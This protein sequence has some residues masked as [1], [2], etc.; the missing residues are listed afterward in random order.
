MVLY[1]FPIWMHCT[2]QP[3]AA[4]QRC[5]FLLQFMRCCSHFAA[6]PTHINLQPMHSW[7][8]MDT[9]IV[10]IALDWNNIESNVLHRSFVG[11]PI[12]F[13]TSVVDLSWP[14]HYPFRLSLS[15]TT[16]FSPMFH[17]LSPHPF[18]LVS[19]LNINPHLSLPCCRSFISRFPCLLLLPAL[20]SN[21]AQLI[22]FKAKLAWLHISN[23]YHQ[24]S[25]SLINF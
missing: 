7:L 5:S 1:C 24:G 3:L 6:V 20:L 11:G 15:L 16:S 2:V 17:C 23:Q 21:S 18:T 19:S 4:V 8:G 12:G 10:F 25:I 22:R 14:M 13:V 9:V